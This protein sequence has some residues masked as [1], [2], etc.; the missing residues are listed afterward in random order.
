MT[1]K[2]T[3]RKATGNQER[4]QLKKKKTNK[5][6]GVS[7]YLSIVTVNINGLNSRDTDW[8]IKNQNPTLYY[9][10]ETY[11]TTKDRVNFKG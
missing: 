7:T 11:L 2:P 6:T 5:M 1:V 10:R 3:H 4:E 9:L 8:Q